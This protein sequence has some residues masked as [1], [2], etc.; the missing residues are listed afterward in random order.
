M[1]TMMFVRLTQSD[2][3]DFTKGYEFLKIKYDWNH[4]YIILN[5]KLVDEMK[6]LNDKTRKSLGLFD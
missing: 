4:I 6:N 3:S 2:A 1:Q 5:I